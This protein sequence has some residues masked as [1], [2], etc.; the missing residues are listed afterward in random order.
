M[1]LTKVTYSMIEGAVANVLDYGA[2]PTGV[3]DSRA[4]CQTAITALQA[5]GGG[6][7]FFPSGSYLLTPVASSDALSNGLVVPYTSANS[8][9][10]RIV[11][12]GEGRSTILKA[13]GDSMYIVRFSD[14]HG[15]VK[16]MTLDGNG[17]ASV[18]G[19]GCVPENTTQTTTLVFQNYNI[20]SGLYIRS[21]NEGFTLRC[22]PDVTGSD[23]GCWY[24]ILKD[25]H[26]YFCTRGIWLQ[27]GPN[28]SSSS[29]NRNSF[30]NIRIG[31]STNT[32][33][34][35]DSADTCKFYSVSFEGVATGTSPN[36][37]PTAI[38]IASAST[39]ATDNNQNMFFGC[40]F[41]SNTRDLANYNSKSQFYGCSLNATKVLLSGGASYGL[42]CIGGIDASNTPQLMP[43]SLYQTNLQ[44]PAY[45]NGTSFIGTSGSAGV[46]LNSSIFS[47]VSFEETSGTSG[48]VANGA[49]FDITVPAIRR[50][51]LLFLYS[52]YNIGASSI[53]FVSG[54]GAIAPTATSIVTPASAPTAAGN[55][56]TVIRV[57]NNYGG[58][59]IIKWTLT[60]FG[61]AIP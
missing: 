13:N 58:A 29:N 60:P 23:S 19:L 16:D 4:A 46:S 41:E 12:Q 50:P 49:T 10:N 7:V 22:G 25:T 15:G 33:L 6:T 55:G 17:K 56:T 32:G 21:C 30:F 5:A 27:N 52:G 42:L 45:P 24:N 31:Q 3:A 40:E 61:A 26:I 11:L 1:S 34:Q 57:T 38:Y 51:Q 2:D 48:S 47:S 53:Y 44:L 37:T 59:A 35:I 8:S 39:W 14:S 18:V 36:A 28:A 43:G 54:D 9:A 20:F